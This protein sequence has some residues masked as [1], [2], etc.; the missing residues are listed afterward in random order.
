[1][2]ADDAKT[3]RGPRANIVTFPLWKGFLRLSAAALCFFLWL[4]LT[5]SAR[6]QGVALA[7]STNKQP[8]LIRLR[9]DRI[10][11]YYDRYLVEADGNVRVT[12]TSGMTITGDAFSMDLKLDR[13]LVAGNVHLTSPGGNLDGAAISDF[14]DFDRV[15]FVPVIGEPDRWTYLNGDFTHPLKGRRMPGD[16]FY[17]PDLS[18]SKPD[19]AAKSATIGAGTFVRFSGVTSYLFS[20]KVPMPSFY[21]Y[22]GENQNLVQ[23]SLSGANFDL[24]WNAAGDANSISGVHA[25]YDSSNGPYLS[26]EQ[27][28]AGSHEY[29][30]FSDNP[31]T[32]RKHFWN[33]FTGD[34]LTSRLQIHTFAQLYEDQAWFKQP[35]ASS[36]VNYI[37]ATQAFNQSYLSAA[38][39]LVN[40]MLIPTQP[41]I[42]DHP[43]QLQLSATTFNHRIFK[44]PLYEQIYYGM[45]FIHDSLTGLTPA[46][47]PLQY[48]GGVYYTTIWD[49]NLG[50]TVYLP[51]IKFGNTD[52][53]YKTY[54]FNASVSA[55]RTWYSV[56]HHVNTA[57][58]TV[59]VS[60]QFSRQVHTYL[61]YSVNDTSDVYNH[62]GYSP[63]VPTVNGTPVYSFAAFRGA[64][65]L[66]TTTLGINY[67]T[68]PNL[69]ATL[70]FDHHDDFPVPVPGLFPLPPLN[71]IGQYLYTNYLGQPPWDVTGDLRVRVLP[72]LVVDVQR[73]YYFHFGSQVW[74]PQFVVQLS[75]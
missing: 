57:T 22:F 41:S 54:F 28:L 48:Y 4:A 62:G 34:N 26:F 52:Y 63:F 18:T 69:V 36:S 61:S 1:M 16:T 44:T 73:T 43:T 75:Q 35:Y 68:N 2:S 25:R 55:G 13:F 67:S 21:V 3:R 7:T 23:N 5:G 72:H 74:S 66:R 70:T 71:N 30:V 46:A 8:T 58:T 59:S 9:A 40:Y 56:P 51:G 47:H 37:F 31:A 45:G 10:S 19:L 32:K 39:T 60:R 14:L 38:A 17:F 15:Y 29:A 12:T 33:L 11:F 24:T 6:A 42:P 50:Y 53:T 65:T 64:S 49:H 27:H 20:V